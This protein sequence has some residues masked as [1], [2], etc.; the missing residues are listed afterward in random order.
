[1]QAGSDNNVIPETALLKANLR[2]YSAGVREQMLK[3]IKAV[4]EGIART[5]GMPEDQLPVITMKGGSTPLVNQ[6][7]L[8][9]RLALSLKAAVGDEAVVTDFPPA[10]GSED[11]HLLVG[12]YKDTPFP[13][14]AHNPNFIVDLAAIPTGTKVATVAMLDLLGKSAN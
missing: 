2:W 11:V 3:G 5:Y 9:D 4:S 6:K 1:M 12:P 14:S 10:T 8:A 13:Y 7:E